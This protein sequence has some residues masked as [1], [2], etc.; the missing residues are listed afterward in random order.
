MD[1]IRRAPH[2]LR[3]PAERRGK[4]EK[5]L[6]QQMFADPEKSRPIMLRSWVLAAMNSARRGHSARRLFAATFCAVLLRRI[7]GVA[8]AK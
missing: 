8:R 5:A 2:G 1:D 3:G 6:P 4:H 7:D